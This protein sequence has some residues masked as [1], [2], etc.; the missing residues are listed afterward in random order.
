MAL[1]LE[2]TP[3]VLH[4]QLKHLSQIML[5]K[6]NFGNFRIEFTKKTATSLKYKNRKPLK[7]KIP[8]YAWVLTCVI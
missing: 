7:K 5:K 4:M 2:L 3:G 8:L 1:N 6:W